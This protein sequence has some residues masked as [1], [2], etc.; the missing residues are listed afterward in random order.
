MQPVPKVVYRSSCAINTTAHSVIRTWSSH[1]ADERAI[2]SA[3]VRQR[4]RLPPGL[5]V[6]TRPLLRSV[7]KARKWKERENEGWEKC[8]PTKSGE[9]EAEPLTYERSPITQ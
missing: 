6:G 3:T 7:E 9:I 5:C 8:D 4:R 1:T 2:H